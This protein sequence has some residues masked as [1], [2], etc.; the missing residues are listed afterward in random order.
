[1]NSKER[2]FRL[3]NGKSIDVLP[4]APHWW[5][6]YKFQIAGIARKYEDED[7][8]WKL[9]GEKLA[10]VDSL[11]YEKFK[12]DWFQL[13]SGLWNHDK[14]RQIKTVESLQRVRLLESKSDV[15]EYVKLA[16]MTAEEIK[17][18]GAY[19]HVKIL[20]SRYG[21]EVFIAMNE[22]NPIC[23]ILDPHGNI[24]FEEGMVALLEK[25]DMMEYLIFKEY[26]MMFEKV[27]VLKEYGCDAYIGSETYCTPD[28]ISPDVYRNIIFPAQKYF[29]EKTRS[30][31]VVPITYFLGDVMPLLKDIDKLGVS[32]L[33]VEE[34]KKTFKLDVVEIRKKLSENITLFGNLDSVYTLLKGTIEDVENETEQQVEASKYGGFIMANGCPIAFDTPEENIEAMIT[35]ARNKLF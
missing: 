16:Y 13:N 10:D 27:K 11:F 23:T 22:G 35:A 15:D 30:L 6:L 17:A 8:C 14:Y 25:P 7:K 34:S 24:G 26:E 9:G 5:G 29:Y 20:A 28:L 31:G 12:P 33:M 18:A 3:L 1:M 19:E 32:A 2:M 21:D 4:V